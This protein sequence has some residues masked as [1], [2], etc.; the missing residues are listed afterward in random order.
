MLSKVTSSSSSPLHNIEVWLCYILWGV[1][2]CDIFMKLLWERGLVYLCHRKHYFLLR[3]RHTGNHAH[4]SY[5]VSWQ[6]GIWSVNW[7]DITGIVIFCNHAN[8]SLLHVAYFLI[9]VSVNLFLPSKS[10]LPNNCSHFIFNIVTTE[11]NW[12]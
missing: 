7:C 4:N 5:K 6:L 10:N 1:M 2:L 8:T 3:D 11:F 12:G 9:L